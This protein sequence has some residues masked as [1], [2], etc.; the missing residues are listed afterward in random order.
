MA[1]NRVLSIFAERPKAWSRQC[2]TGEAGFSNKGRAEGP[3][4]AISC[5]AAEA[6]SRRL[7]RI[8]QG[9]TGE[10]GFQNKVRAE[11]PTVAISYRA[12]EAVLKRL[13]LIRHCPEQ[14]RQNRQ[15]PFLNKVRA[16]GPTVASSCRAA[17]AV[18]RRFP[19][20]ATA[21]PAKPVFKT[22][23]GPKARL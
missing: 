19:G 1:E 11:G 6:V 13:P 14:A 17:E 15:G 3:T 16:E 7:P 12:A 9:K 5:R 10:A 22:K 4:V 2:K 23:F 18:P 21:K 8:R 20:A